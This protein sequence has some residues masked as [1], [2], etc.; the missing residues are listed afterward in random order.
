MSI[1]IL[2]AKTSIQIIFLVFVISFGSFITYMLLDF[3]NQKKY[4]DTIIGIFEN[5]DK[6]FLL[7][8]VIDKPKCLYEKIVYNLLKE[9]DR[10][11]RNNINYYKNMQNDYKEYIENWVR[12]IK[13]PIAST[14]LF[15]EN[16]LI[17]YYF[18]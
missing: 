16:N 7:S 10:S 8:E 17:Q 14:M 5:L 1:A 3:I 2:V 13:T 11:I 4:Y 15:I 12:E 6:K 9:S 18:I